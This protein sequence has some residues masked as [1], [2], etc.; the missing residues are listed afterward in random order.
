MQFTTFSTRFLLLGLSVMTFFFVGCVDQDFDEPPSTIE[1]PDISA[2]TTISQLKEKHIAGEFESI[3]EDLVIEGIVVADDASGNFYRTLIIQDG[4]GGIELRLNSNELYNDYPIGR[5]LF[6]KCNGLTMGD[7]NGIVQLGGGT[8]VDDRG[9]NRLGGIEDIFVKDVLL[10]G[11]RNNEVT[12]TVV[13]ID[14]LTTDIQDPYI[15][16]LVQINDVQFAT[17]SSGETY[18]LYDQATNTRSTVNRDLEDC[19]GNELVLRSSGFAD[20]VNELT[21]TGKGSITGVYSV[22]RTTRQFYIRTIEDVDMTDPRCGGGTNTGNEELISLAD[23]RALYSGTEI[24]MPADKKIKG[25]VISDRNTNHL[26]DN[27]LVIQDADGGGIVLRFADPHTFNINEELEVVVSGIELSEFNDVLQINGIPLSNGTILGTGAVAPREI[28]I[29]ELIADH[30]TLESTLVKIDNVTISG[31]GTYGSNT[32]LD[33]GTNN[34]ALYTSG[35]SSFAS[36]R[37]PS[38]STTI[39]AIVSEFQGTKQLGIRSPQDVVGGLIGGGDE[40]LNESFDATIDDAAIEL[41]D[42][43]NIIVKGTR[44]WIGKSF[45]GNRFAQQTAFQD[46]SPEMESWLVTPGITMDVEKVLTF[47][48]AQAFWVH[49]GLTVLASTDFDGSDVVS[50]NWK[51]LNC[52]IAGENDDRYAWIESGVVDLS[53]FSGKVYIAFRYVGNKDNQTS[54]YRIDNIVVREK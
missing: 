6:V 9:F 18:A 7:Y 54:T 27:N 3:T 4:T 13:T 11:T 10:R 5:Q 49:D 14:Q 24:P 30:E 44:N 12:P 2:N 8:Y 31:G 33:D 1:L 17:G 26:D 37:Y 39:T 53:E 34:I 25:V 43:S 28:T 50:A 42:W 48:T 21:P 29:D 16:T 19:N 22:F 46:S 15:N 40:D 45:S 20:F 51:E 36:D 38:G 35:R 47:E 52:T 41:A 32:T 23:V